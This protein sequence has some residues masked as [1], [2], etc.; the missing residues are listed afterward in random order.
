MCCLAIWFQN[1]SL[2]HFSM[3]HGS[4]HITAVPA[5]ESEV[6]MLLD[7]E[8]SSFMSFLLIELLC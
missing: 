7:E 1:S 8:V 5:S 4:H 3:F 6:K 2:Y